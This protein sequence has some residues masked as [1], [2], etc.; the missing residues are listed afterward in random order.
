MREEQQK[1][2]YAIDAETFQKGIQLINCLVV[3]NMPLND[4]MDY[5]D[6]NLERFKKGEYKGSFLIKT[7]ERRTAKEG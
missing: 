4:I 6:K 2:E 1:S 7:Y 5:L 3:L